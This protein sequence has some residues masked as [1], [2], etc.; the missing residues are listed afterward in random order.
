MLVKNVSS[1]PHWVGDV[2]I[3]P[4]ETKAVS[5]IYANAIN[6]QELV[7]L[8]SEKPEPKKAKKTKEAEV[9]ALQDGPAK[10]AQAE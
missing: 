9:V 5:D 10:D 6:Q 3:A 7:S 1:R 8:E 4:N 2:L